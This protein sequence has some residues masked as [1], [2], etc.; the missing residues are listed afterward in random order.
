M[1]VLGACSYL[2]Q[3]LLTRVCCRNELGKSVDSISM[4]MDSSLVPKHSQSSLWAKYSW[5]MTDAALPTMSARAT[6]A[7]ALVGQRGP[8]VLT[9]LP[10]GSQLIITNPRCAD[11][12]VDCLQTSDCSSSPG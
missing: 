5:D 4:S 10:Q 9:A 1:S 12:P 8:L 6:G 3:N 2:A 11:S 7:S